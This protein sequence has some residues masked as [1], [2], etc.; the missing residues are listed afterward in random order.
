M[1]DLLAILDNLVSYIPSFNALLASLCW[2]IGALFVIS[3]VFHASR[4]YDFGVSQGSWKAPIAKFVIGVCFIALPS[5]ITTM[6]GTFWGTSE[7]E[8]AEAI[9]QYAPKMTGIFE[10]NDTR[11]LVINL[12]LI[13]KVIG[14]IGFVRGLFLLN[15][16][17]SGTGGART[18]GQGMTFVIASTMA[19]NFPLFI[20]LIEKLVTYQT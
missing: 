11:K 19:I 4:R 13:V 14:F 10:D 17:A 15:H 12:V 3:S 8:S 7:P 2:I 1:A 5:L 16:A 6:I 18:F 20:M 9:F